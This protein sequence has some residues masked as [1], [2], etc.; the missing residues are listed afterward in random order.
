MKLRVKIFIKQRKIGMTTKI[1]KDLSKPVLF[2][3]NDNEI[4]EDYFKKLSNPSYDF[5]KEEEENK[6]LL[7]DAYNNIKDL[8]RKYCDL[9]EED[10]PI[11]ATWIIGTYFHDQFHSYP[12]LFLNAMKGSGKTRTLKLI[13]DLSKDGEILLRPTEAVLFRTRSTLGIDEAEGLT[14]KGMEEIRE[15][16]NGCYKKGSKVK[17]MK[18]K[19][20]L[21]GVE[22]VIEEFDIYR[23]LILANINGMEDVLGDRC[24]S[25]ILER[26]TNP[27]IVK[28]AEIWEDEKMFKK[29][30]EILNQCRVCNV[31]VPWKLYSE[32]NNYIYTTYIL[33]N[34]YTN[35]I[36]YTELFK[37]LNLMDLNG[38][39]VELSAP[40]LFIAYNI[41]ESTYT[42]VYSGIKLYMES[43]KQDQF[44]ES[45]DVMLI[46]MVSQEP[47]EEW[48]TSKEILNKYFQFTQIENKDGE[49][50]SRWIGIA[51]KRLNLIKDKKRL[52][53]GM[54]YILNIK[55][56][57]EKIKQFK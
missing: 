44:N 17:R 47:K 11:I 20:T 28:L 30:K 15:L 2:G 37:S 10:Y 34:N 48:T 16:L 40:L 22:Q 31:V 3:L 42:E 52:P 55:K 4:D 35:S 51:L 9:K 49:I 7:Y 39:E 54:R 12:Y 33:Y 23:P 38:R 56:A 46:D 6:N 5:E 24:I 18:Q 27:G 13:T 43:R 21:E 14:R 41:D 32:W 57:Q 29:T 45:Q 50:N 8:L 19:K 26:S 53:G 25:I 36:N 1:E